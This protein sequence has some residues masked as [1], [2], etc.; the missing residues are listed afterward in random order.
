MHVITYFPSLS[1]SPCRG[2]APVVAVECDRQRPWVAD[3]VVDAVGG[4]EGDGGGEEGS[5]AEG[6]ADARGGRE[7]A[8]HEAVLVV[9][10]LLGK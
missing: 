4:G 2:A 6:G 8:S 1:I 5:P 10:R 7:E 3:A 9:G